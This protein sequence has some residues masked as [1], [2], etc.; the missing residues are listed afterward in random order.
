MIDS[1]STYGTHT[2]GV[3]DFLMVPARAAAFDIAA[4]CLSRADETFGC[5]NDHLWDF[6]LDL[7]AALTWEGSDVEPNE[8]AE[9]N[10]AAAGRSEVTVIRVAD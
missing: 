3:G 9:T 7:E 8:D 10:V 2:K 5:I 1:T 6:V 4:A